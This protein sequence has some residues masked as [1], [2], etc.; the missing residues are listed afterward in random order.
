MI[1]MIAAVGKNL[2]LGYMGDLIW[3]IKDDMKFFRKTTSGKTIIMGRKTFDSLGGLLT[4]RHHVVIT[5][6]RDFSF[7]SVDVFHS[8]EEAF[9]YFKDCD[10]EVFV[11]GGGTVYKQ[12][13]PYCDRMYLTEV[14]DEFPDADTFFFEFSKDDFTSE[15][16]D[17]IGDEN[18]SASIVRYDRIKK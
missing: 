11:I 12:F 9:E 5:R 18:V 7:E 8:V 3:H 1:S 15:V 6:S 16:L 17:V 13:L 4:N 14:D 2:E 10:D